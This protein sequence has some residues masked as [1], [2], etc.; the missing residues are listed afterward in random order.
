MYLVYLKYTEIHFFTFQIG[1]NSNIWKDTFEGLWGNRCTHVLLMGGINGDSPSNCQS[2]SVYQNYKVW[3]L[4]AQQSHISKFI[5]QMEH[6]SQ[7][8][9]PGFFI[10]GPESFEIAK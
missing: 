7:C 9:V 6:H 5:L 4:L 10:C 8:E 1:K 3:Y 2:G